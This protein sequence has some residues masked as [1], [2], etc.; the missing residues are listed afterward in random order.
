M[1]QEFTTEAQCPVCSAWPPADRAAKREFL[2]EIPLHDPVCKRC[3]VT[4]WSNISGQ[5]FTEEDLEEALRLE[6]EGKG[7]TIELPP[8]GPRQ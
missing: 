6:A 2:A 3:F 4:F 1:G 7:A 5:H 8:R